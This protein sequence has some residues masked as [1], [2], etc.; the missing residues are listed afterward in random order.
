[1]Q[2]LSSVNWQLSNQLP[3]VN[4]LTIYAAIRPK[5]AVVLLLTLKRN[6]LE[7]SLRHNDSLAK[8]ITLEL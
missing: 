8:E 5:S 1:M 7:D 2:D 3:T 6:P 4:S